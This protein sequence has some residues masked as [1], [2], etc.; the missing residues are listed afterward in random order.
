M[1]PAAPPPDRS[2]PD[3]PTRVIPAWQPPW[4]RDGRPAPAHA[5][6]DPVIQPPIFPNLED[7]TMPEIPDELRDDLRQRD[8][9]RDPDDH[10][11]DIIDVGGRDPILEPDIPPAPTE[12]LTVVVNASLA[13][14][15]HGARCIR[16]VGTDGHLDLTARQAQRLMEHLGR[17][18]EPVATIRQMAGFNG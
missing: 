3:L 7:R 1:A 17:V 12:E 11:G 14:E 18:I 16:I 15:P 10:R 8:R 6:T 9:D 2:P 4:T 13:G 5:H